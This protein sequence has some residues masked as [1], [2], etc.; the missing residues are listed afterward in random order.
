MS[1][2][3]GKSRNSFQGGK[4]LSYQ[5]PARSLGAGGC[6]GSGGHAIVQLLHRALL[7]AAA[8][9]HLYATRRAATRTLVHTHRHGLAGLPIGQD[10]LAHQ[11][12][13]TFYR[14]AT[15]Y[16]AC[17][18][19]D[20]LRRAGFAIDAWGQ[21]LA[22]SLSETREMEPLHPGHGRCAFVVVSASRTR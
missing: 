15:F 22:R 10:Y 16:S 4:Q 13:S 11:T 5:N 21:T 2:V 17:E 1:T 20:L 18:V 12:E 14:D 19:A 6:R 8:I 3:A 7:G 9:A